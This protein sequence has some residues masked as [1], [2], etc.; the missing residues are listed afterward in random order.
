MIDDR[1]LIQ[2]L[3]LIKYVYTTGAR[4]ST[5]PE[6][7]S[8]SAL[9]LY[10]DA[11]ELFLQLGA[12]H[13]D[14]GASQMAFMDYWEVFGKEPH[15]ILLMQKEGMRRLNR[16]RVDLKHHGIMPS[17]ID[18]E[19]FGIST[20]TF[21]EENTPLLF[22]MSFSDI[23]MINLVSSD[24]VRSL[25]LKAD[26]EKSTDPKA[27]VESIALAFHHIIR[28]YETSTEDRFHRSPYRFDDSMHFLTPFFLHVNDISDSHI[29]DILS[30]YIGGISETLEE[31]Q[32]AIRIVALG[33]DFRKYS[34]FKKSTP[35]MVWTLNGQCAFGH[36]PDSLHVLHVE[37][38]D[39]QIDFCIDTYLKLAEVSL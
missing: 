2:R 15:K 8:V 19:S 21:F 36:D 38:I 7:L 31:M 25:L 37:D 28:E 22:R 34:S 23:S 9:L 12:E 26:S 4:E 1:G 24:T 11:V 35:H 29:R 6:P 32:D 13:F 30:R 5:K 14:V 39:R 27:S 33:I 20:K 18:L 16:S 17:R 3:S 10:Q